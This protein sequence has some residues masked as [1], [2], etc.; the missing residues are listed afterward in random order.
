MNHPRLAVAACYLG[1][2]PDYFSFVARTMSYN[3]H[4]EWMIF[5][6]SISE[7]VHIYANV[8]LLPITINE[9]CSRLE[10][11]GGIKPNI[12]QYHQIC[13][14][15]PV[16]GLAFADYFKSYDFWG[17]CDL[18]VIYGDLLHFL[19]PSI[20]EQNDRVL[21]RGHLSFYRNVPEV[22]R[23]F[24]LRAP[25]TI[26]HLQMF[27]RPDHAQFDEWKGI[28]R[29]M[30]Y[31]GFRQYHA[32]LC[33]DIST[34]TRYKNTR[35]TATELANYRDQ[36]F[37][38]WQGKAFRAYLHREGGM[39]DDEVLYIHFQKRKLPPIN[40]ALITAK[41][42]GIGPQGFFPYDREYLSTEQIGRLNKETFKP[43]IDIVRDTVR[44]CLRGVRRFN[45]GKES[46]RQ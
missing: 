10:G 40:S 41:G 13:S 39:L 31:H 25:Q 33:A 17:H 3:E 38:W 46:S 5:T 16:Y 29:I 34:P 14:F 20:F 28:H 18:D 37:Y 30:R 21:C 4:I 2:M 1:Q 9:L 35:F 42:V 44:G 23:A 15:R 12:T 6:D 27:I 11:A 36:I 19:T 26:S 24:L 43:V 8:Q 32:E 45:S 7:S 22:N